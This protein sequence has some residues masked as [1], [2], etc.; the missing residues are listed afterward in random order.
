MAECEARMLAGWSRARRLDYLDKVERRRGLDAVVA[1]RYHLAR[2][3][4]P[5]HE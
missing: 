2:L 4:T 5:R 3:P 1:L